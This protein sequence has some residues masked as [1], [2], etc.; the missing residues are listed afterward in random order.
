[1]EEEFIMESDIIVVLGLA[2]VFFG[3]IGYILWKENNRNKP[4]TAETQTLSQ[5]NRQSIEK[6]SKRSLRGH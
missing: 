5:D 2:L 4:Q 3:G 1:M 6:L